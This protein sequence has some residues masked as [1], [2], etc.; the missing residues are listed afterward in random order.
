MSRDGVYTLAEVLAQGFEARTVGVDGARYLWHRD[1]GER[2]AP[3]TGQR[4]RLT[5]PA[6]L[7]EGLWFP[8]ARGLEELASAAATEAGA[9]AEEGE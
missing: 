2:V 7:P 9:A 8:T 1:C 6:A 5:D 4:T 3:R